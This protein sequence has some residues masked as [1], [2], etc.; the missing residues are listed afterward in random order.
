MEYS[1]Q[2]MGNEKCVFHNGKPF[3]TVFVGKFKKVETHSG[4]GTRKRTL[5]KKTTRKM[6]LLNK[7]EFETK[8]YSDEL[9]DTRHER[10]R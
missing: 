1:W 10:R 2:K 3:M 5:S 4:F 9:S 8:V 6:G 7:A